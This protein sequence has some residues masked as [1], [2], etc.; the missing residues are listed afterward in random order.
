MPVTRLCLAVGALLLAAALGAQAPAA[1]DESVLRDWRNLAIADCAPAF[2]AEGDING[3]GASDHVVLFSPVAGT[4]AGPEAARPL[5]VFL[6]EPDGRYRV[7]LC[8]HVVLPLGRDGNFPDS[9][10]EAT[11]AGPLLTV[12]QY[13]GFVQ[14]WGRETSFRY[15][16]VSRHVRFESDLLTWFDARNDNAVLRERR[17]G[18][19]TIGAVRFGSFDL[20]ALD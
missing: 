5:A 7:E 15:D 17:I 8:R 1:S 3:D 9:F 12:V 13:G 11:V 10:V 4:A 20:D 16:P 19:E 14:R 18:R 2:H 6:S